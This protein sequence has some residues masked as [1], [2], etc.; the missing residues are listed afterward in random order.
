MRAARGHTAQNGRIKAVTVS[1]RFGTR[2]ASAGSAGWKNEIIHNAVITKPSKPWM[3]ISLPEAMPA[4]A[5]ASVAGVGGAGVGGRGGG[6]AASLAGE[7]A[8]AA[9]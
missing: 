6:G 8:G 1:S 3:T 9:G 4:T 2:V 5:G 7:E